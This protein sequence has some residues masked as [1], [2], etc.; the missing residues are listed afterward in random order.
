MFRTARLGGF[1]S[2][3]TTCNSVGGPWFAAVTLALCFAASAFA[4]Q[5][6]SPAPQ[7]G[8]VR[9]PAAYEVLTRGLN[10][11]AG[12]HE[13]LELLK[14]D[15][16]ELKTSV[17]EG[18]NGIEETLSQVRRLREEILALSAE[19]Q[20][21]RAEKTAKAERPAAVDV[22]TT[23]SLGRSQLTPEEGKQIRRA[24]ELMERGDVAGARLLLE[25]AVRSHKSAPLYRKLAETY[26]PERLAAIQVLGSLGDRNRADELYEQARRLD[27]V[28]ADRAARLP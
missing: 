8:T 9:D 23:G 13:Q 7:N 10:E 6:P 4:Q 11:R 3:R 1:G 28:A 22:D 5:S 15:I 18:E 19:V 16:L 12:E 26:D 2:R 24:G 20:T 25:Y 27:T 17:R 14:R 21:I